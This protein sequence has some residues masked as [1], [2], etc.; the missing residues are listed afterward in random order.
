MG[1][2]ASAVITGIGQNRGRRGRTPSRGG[3]AAANSLLANS[4]LI[5]GPDAIRRSIGAHPVEGH[6]STPSRAMVGA[7]MHIENPTCQR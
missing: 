2:S 5:L 6:K 4:L 3:P 1:S 7:Q